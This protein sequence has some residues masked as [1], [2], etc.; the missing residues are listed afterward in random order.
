MIEEN[1]PKGFGPSNWAIDNRFTIFIITAILIF[2]GVSTYES[3]PKEQFPEIV[4]PTLYVST[5]Y[6]GTSPADME[7]LVTRPLEKQI[8]G[9]T[10]IKKLTST[11]IQDFSS[12]VVEF[13]TEVDIAEAK[14]KVKDA[15]D[16]ARPDLPTDLPA[17]PNVIDVDL[18]EIPVMNVNVSGNLELSRLK[19]YAEEI[20][21]LIEG[22]KTVNRVDLVGVLDREVQVDVDMFKMQAAK[23]TMDDIE[24]AI[25]FENMTVS[26]GAINTGQMKRSIRVDGEFERADEI[27]GIYVTSMSGAGVYLRDIAL[28]IDGYKEQESFARLNGQPVLTLNV[29]KRSGENLI[30]TSDEI[31]ARLEEAKKRFPDELKITITGDQSTRTRT[32]VHDLT[33]TIIIGFLLVTLV[34]MFFM[35]TT[36]AMFVG[37]SVPLSSFLAF[38]IM[39]GIDFTMN[40]IV[41]FALLM[42]LGVVVDDAIVVIENTHRL[43]ANGKKR[44]DKAAKEAAG[45]VFM[46]VLAGTLTT[47]A[48]F[49][50]LAF[51]N[52]VVGKFMFFLPITL[53]LTLC[54]SL[55]VAYL[56]NPAFAVQFMKPELRYP[57]PAQLKRRNKL[58]YLV[59]GGL[60]LAGI[61]G[62]LMGSPGLANFLIVVALLLWTN[63]Y[64]FT[65]LIMGFQER[66]WP[67]VQSAYDRFLRI[68]LKGRNPIKIAVGMALLLPITLFITGWAAK[69]GR[70]KVDFFPSGDPNFVYVYLSTPVGS[71]QRYTDSLTR[72]VEAK[73]ARVLGQNNPLVESVIANVTVGAGDPMAGD[74]A[75]ATNKA[76]V[77]VAMVE[78]ARRN[79]VSTKPLLDSIRLAVRDLPGLEVSVDQERGGPPTGKPINIEIA[80][81]DFSI[82]A[83]TSVQLK[84][85]LD[86]L[87]IAGVE[88]LKSNLELNK[89]VMTIKV[90]RERAQ[91]EGISTAQIGSEIRAAVFGMEVSQ[92]RVGNDEIPIQLRYDA[93]SRSQADRLINARI[94][95]R[96]MNSGGAIRQIPLSSVATLEY[97]NSYGS[98]RRKNKKRVVTIS[99]NV[100]SGYTANEVVAEI[101]EALEGFPA[102]EGYSVVL[103]GEQEEQAEAAAFLSRSLLI[104]IGLIFLILVVQFNSLNK[105]LIIMSGIVLSIIGVLL[106][107]V[108]TGMNMSV[109]MS[110]IGLVA[111]AGIVV[112][113]GILMVEF[114]DLLLKDGRISVREAIIEAGKIRMA[115]VLL[116][117]FSTV[118]GLVPL[119]VGLNMDFG[120]LLSEL[121]PGIYLGG[122]SVAFFGPLSWTIIFGLS[123]A[124]FLTLVFV[125]VLYYITHRNQV[126]RRFLM[127]KLERATFGLE[128]RASM[129]DGL[130]A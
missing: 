51:W 43:F 85:Y 91:R 115:P 119:A 56:I 39:P 21:D 22:V 95:F 17:D 117:A 100:L 59:S 50:P 60:V 16:K 103:T 75:A 40:M 109:V 19:T 6:P 4:I 114:T 101:T 82:L 73:V 7:N 97:G 96:D 129:V 26:G 104:S 24:R 9:I 42:A 87:D 64:V 121:N 76:K 74:Q 71:D 23:L 15:V 34:L 8:K 90:D 128:K 54:A 70:L 35:G 61:L 18:S 62:H 92:L 125:P 30:S 98:I 78:Y 113:N 77:T 80:G 130:P 67:A 111:L 68:C 32:T 45:E 108:A 46:P 31:N 11:S 106:G 72:V 27:G 55:I 63:R 29:I 84:K 120:K 36:N 105:T 13:G 25:R 20:Q 10:G 107:F 93:M 53:I 37:L 94:T 126:R 28:I 110:G 99:S 52:G 83:A 88:E 5:V 38:L 116:T 79:G 124:T 44:I 86:S 81:D 66:L 58:L 127:R 47:I 41:L 65:P 123:F 14:Q 2:A 48:P 57:S 49:L 1:K 118:L 12:V 3:I 122:D 102:P 33:N 69:N 112:K 89:P